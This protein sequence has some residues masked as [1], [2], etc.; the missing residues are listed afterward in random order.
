M[1]FRQK[2]QGSGPY[3]NDISYANFK[4]SEINIDL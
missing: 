4:F 2:N 3:Y 1:N